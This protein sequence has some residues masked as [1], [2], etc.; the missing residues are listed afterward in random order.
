MGSL[1]WHLEPSTRQPRRVWA[2]GTVF[3]RGGGGER[4]TGGTYAV[5]HAV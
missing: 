2:R 3:G 5:A 1:E 4:E